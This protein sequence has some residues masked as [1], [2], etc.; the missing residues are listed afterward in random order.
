[1]MPIHADE[2]SPIYS[3]SI[4][5]GNLRDINTRQHKQIY[6]HCETIGGLRTTISE[7]EERDARKTTAIDELQK[8][9]ANR[10]RQIG[11]LGGWKRS[12]LSNDKRL[13]RLLDEHR[14]AIRQCDKTTE[15]L[16]AELRDEMQQKYV[17][18]R[19]GAEKA[20][21]V[22]RLNETISD[23][24]M[25]ASDMLD[26]INE[27]SRREAE[28]SRVLMQVVGWVKQWDATP[29]AHRSSHLD[30]RQIAIIVEDYLDAPETP[31]VMLKDAKQ[32]EETIDEPRETLKLERIDHTAE[33]SAIKKTLHETITKL[34]ALNT[35]LRIDVV[36]RD[37][38]IE[39]LNVE[40]KQ[41]RDTIMELRSLVDG[42]GV[43]TDK[44][45]VTMI[46][47]QA[48]TIEEKNTVL[49][50]YREE[51]T[52]IWSK[53][54]RIEKLVD[55][56]SISRLKLELMHDIRDIIQEDKP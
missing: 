3:E 35:A 52:D 5:I 54:A 6:E 2:L 24:R 12:L 30:M 45:A 21:T 50:A 49:R 48:T 39:E 47:N 19:L 31:V 56:G 33:K 23:L 14:V 38:Y 26:T 8:T 11:N 20:A 9:I 29:P 7:L 42:T 34:K 53:L 25:A 37:R 41:F 55:G 51:N 10:D 4:I 40:I 22:L 46:N 32:L 16:E 1:M 44:Q 17:A 18:I 36:D 13:N 15:S 28:D 27:C 43:I